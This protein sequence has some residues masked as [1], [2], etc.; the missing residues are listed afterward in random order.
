LA[1]RNYLSSYIFIYLVDIYVEFAS[2][3]LTVNT[4]T[5]Y[6]IKLLKSV[7]SSKLEGAYSTRYLS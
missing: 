4:H 2:S 1:Q 3:H 7:S 5:D 6:L